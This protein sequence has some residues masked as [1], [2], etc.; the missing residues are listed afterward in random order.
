MWSVKITLHLLLTFRFT[1]LQD[2]HLIDNDSIMVFEASRLNLAHVN[3]FKHIELPRRH[4]REIFH[5]LV[6]AVKCEYIRIYRDIFMV[7]LQG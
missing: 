7:C 5:Q 3:T 6:A 1:P 4:I 2:V